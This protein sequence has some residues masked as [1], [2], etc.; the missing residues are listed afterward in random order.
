MLVVWFVTGLLPSSAAA[1]I[2]LFKTAIRHI[3][4]GQLRRNA[5]L[6]TYHKV[7]A[8]VKLSWS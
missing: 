3:L 5:K 8:R 2:Y 7:R 6:A 4:S 1:S